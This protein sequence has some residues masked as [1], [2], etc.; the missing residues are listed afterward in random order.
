M[1]AHAWMKVVTWVAWALGGIPPG[2]TH[3][4]FPNMRVNIY[5][6]YAETVI[7]DRLE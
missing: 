6:V 7:E 5:E 1:F 3:G 2:P 4:F